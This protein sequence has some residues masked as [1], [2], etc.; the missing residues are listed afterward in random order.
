MSRSSSLGV[1]GV[2]APGSGAGG[3][4]AP[5]PS[6]LGEQ[7]AS[8]SWS[9]LCAS[10]ADL[11][12]VREALVATLGEA[13]SRSSFV[14]VGLRPALVSLE[15]VME[16][17]AVRQYGL[18]GR[19]ALVVDS[20]EK[21]A[22]LLPTPAVTLAFAL[23]SQ[24]LASGF[25]CTGSGDATF[26]YTESWPNSLPPRWVNDAMTD[27]AFRYRLRSEASD[28]A[29]LRANLQGDTLVV[30]L[31]NPYA[32]NGGANETFTVHLR[33]SD[34][35]KSKPGE[36]PNMPEAKERELV[37][38]IDTRLLGPFFAAQPQKTAGAFAT[39]GAAASESFS[40][41]GGGEDP[42][43]RP[44]SKS[45]CASVLVAT[46]ELGASPPCRPR[47]P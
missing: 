39:G 32:T 2:G 22:E 35:V 44:L 30:T 13:G 28:K 23:H 16:A 26:E 29:T 45:R 12:R 14:G 36:K 38:I 33:V 10:A 42:A 25:I 41:A 47:A 43:K 6:N 37:N 19:L 20:P 18:L 5:R 3:A 9:E 40:T 21:A 17:T 27:F 4:G 1:G 11:R 24:F 46:L 34:F 31:K 7:F 15:T 8:M